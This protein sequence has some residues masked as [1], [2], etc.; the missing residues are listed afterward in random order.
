[1]RSSMANQRRILCSLLLFSLLLV[2]PGSS[3][4]LFKG[5][6]WMNSNCATICKTEGFHG[7]RCR[8]LTRRCFCIKPC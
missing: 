7:G 8:G 6:C 3:L 1:M 5:Q 2:A 4:P